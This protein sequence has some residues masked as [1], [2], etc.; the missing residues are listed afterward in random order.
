MAGNGEATAAS[1]GAPSSASTGVATEEPPTPNKPMQIPTPAPASTMNGHDARC[2]IWER[3]LPGAGHRRGPTPATATCAAVHA[4]GCV[5]AWQP[6]RKKRP[7]G[8]P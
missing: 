6:R 5:R 2:V 1:P 7:L 4:G 3:R 8:R